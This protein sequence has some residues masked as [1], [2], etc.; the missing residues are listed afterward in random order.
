MTFGKFMAGLLLIGGVAYL[1]YVMDVPTVLI[2]G[3][4]VALAICCLM[5]GS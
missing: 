2:I 4:S 1:G 5:S 3:L